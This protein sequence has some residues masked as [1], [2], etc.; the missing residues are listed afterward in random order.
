MSDTTETRYAE[1]IRRGR[2]GKE[3]TENE[4]LTEI[5]DRMEADIV[6]AWADAPARD[7]EGK[8]ELWKLYR[9]SQKFRAMLQM[10]IANGEFAKRQLEELNKQPLAGRI[11]RLVGV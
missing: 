3:L 7:A 8:E 10:A 6:K 9:T 1:E 11:R 4:L 5:L 2:L